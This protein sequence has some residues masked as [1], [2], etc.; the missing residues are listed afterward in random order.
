MLLD[1]NASQQIDSLGARLSVMMWPWKKYLNL[2]LLGI[3]KMVET[4]YTLNPIPKSMT[5]GNR[6]NLKDLLERNSIS[7]F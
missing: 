6:L 2:K 5:I 7:N 1:L 3:A 4:T